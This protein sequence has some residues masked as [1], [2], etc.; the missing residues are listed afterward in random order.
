M[1][2]RV[3][4]RLSRRLPRPVGTIGARACGLARH[5]TLIDL[6]AATLCQT[7]APEKE[8]PTTEQYLIPAEQASA[9]PDEEEEEM[10]FSLTT[11]RLVP[12][13]KFLAANASATGN[14]SGAL[15]LSVL[16]SATQIVESF[17]SLAVAL[18]QREWKVHTRRYA[19]PWLGAQLTARVQGLEVRAGETPVVL[20]TEGRSGLPMEYQ[21]EPARRDDSQ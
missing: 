6:P 7:A 13:H 1:D 14:A 9:V 20:A 11:G 15:D 21:N 3:H 19:Q 12:N 2:R 16:N 17:G 8:R 4:D 5:L 18:S 10:R